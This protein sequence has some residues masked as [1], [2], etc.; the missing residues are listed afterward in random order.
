MVQ[1]NSKISLYDLYEI[2]MLYLLTQHSLFHCK[3]HP[4]LLYKCQ[5]R[6][7]LL[8][9][10]HVCKIIDH[11]DQVK[12]YDRLLHRWIDKRKHNRVKYWTVKD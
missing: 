12:Y 4:F 1:S 8:K 9:L 10:D 6:E 3:H 5:R 2:K 11:D 7:G